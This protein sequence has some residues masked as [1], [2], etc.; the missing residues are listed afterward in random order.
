M[1][2][3]RVT[4]I[5]LSCA[6]F[7]TP[8][9]AADQS[10]DLEIGLVLGYDSN[11]LASSGEAGSGSFAE[12]RLDTGTRVGFMEGRVSMFLDADGSARNHQ[13]S[14][15]HADDLHLE[16]RG[17][18]ALVPFS[19][20]RSKV[21]LALG[22]SYGVHRSTFTDP[23]TGEIY[24]L[25]A[26]SPL[27]P[28]EGEEIP[29]RFDYDDAGAFVDLRWKVNRRLRISLEGSRGRTDFTEDY[30]D[31]D[32]LQ[33]LDSRADTVRPS[34][35]FKVADSVWIELF[36]SW[37]DRKYDRQP[38]R[39]ASGEE[40]AGVMRDF[41]YSGYGVIVRVAPAT[42]WRGGFG[43]IA[44]SRNDTYA[45]YYDSTGLTSYTW[46]SRKAGE[47][48]LIQL[49][50]SWREQDYENV[51]IANDPDGDLRGNDTTRIIGR[52]EREMKGRFVLYFE[53]GSER[54]GDRDPVYTYS[55]NWASTGFRFRIK[56][57]T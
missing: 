15:S 55:Q 34:V 4:P 10:S 52:Y 25:A 35:L 41:S 50:G 30:A 24:R 23:V 22:V 6:L 44:S 13:S 11:P 26:S 43:T 31:I 47:R 29:D 14:L 46:L 39:D 8:L 38:A 40:V 53:A 37:T 56:G 12:L 7:F 49:L 51:V 3:T 1:Y 18:L 57:G 36:G 16:T 17:G 19:G 45:G 54:S 32:S 9:P 27:D 48:G 28:E 2:V 5:L 20:V 21:S 33:S 42:R